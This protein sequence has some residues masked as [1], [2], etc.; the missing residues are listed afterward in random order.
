MTRGIAS[1]MICAG[2]DAHVRVLCPVLDRLLKRGV[3]PRSQGSIA[4]AEVGVLEES[5]PTLAAGGGRRGDSRVMCT[6]SSAAAAVAL[7]LASPLG[8][9]AASFA[10]RAAISTRGW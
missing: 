8:V 6:C 2:G 4:T 3:A 10:N 9:A 7:L 1:G 5:T